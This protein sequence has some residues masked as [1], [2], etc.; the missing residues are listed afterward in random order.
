MKKNL[1]EVF[2]IYEGFLSFASRE[3]RY[4]RDFYETAKV[5]EAGK[6]STTL[7]FN[8]GFVVELT[9]QRDVENAAE[10]RC[11]WHD[12]AN[13]LEV[14]TLEQLKQEFYRS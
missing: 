5:N 6:E 3:L 9:N 7:K 14:S 11:W 1:D 8:N 13:A 2:E 12:K 10:L 4:F